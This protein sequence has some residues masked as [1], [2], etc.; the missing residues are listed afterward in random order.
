MVDETDL[1]AFSDAVVEHAQQVDT[2]LDEVDQVKSLFQGKE[3]QMVF[4]SPSSPTGQNYDYGYEKDYPLHTDPAVVSGTANLDRVLNAQPTQSE[5]FNEWYRASHGGND[6]YPSDPSEVDSWSFDSGTNTI[7]CTVNS[8]TFLS[9]ISNTSYQDVVVEA[10]VN[11]SAG[12]DD[13]VGVVAAFVEDNQGREHTLTVLRNA[14]GNGPGR[15]NVMYNYQQSDQQSLAQHTGTL[16]ESPTADGGSGWSTWSEGCRLRVELVGDQLIAKTSQHSDDPNDPMDFVEEA[17]LTVDL[18]S[19]PV[20][21]KFRG[22]K[23]YGYGCFS[24][25]QSAFNVVSAPKPLNTIYDAFN[26]TFTQWDGQNWVSINTTV[27]EQFKPGRFYYNLV[28]EELFYSA[29]HGL[30]RIHGKPRR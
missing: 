3:G 14:G 4:N 5:I 16:T 8:R 19:D 9:F 15:F 12:D 20:L 27:E 7:S 1:T 13:T 21:D 22:V 10:V 23:R 25:N 17:T 11:S 28:T 24:Q 2:K 18:T 29:S 26:D 6:E 30:V